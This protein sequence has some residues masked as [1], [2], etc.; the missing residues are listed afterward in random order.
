MSYLLGL[1]KKVDE[2][3]L[4]KEH[5]TEEERKQIKIKKIK[6]QI[7]N[8]VAFTLNISVIM[9]PL[10]A[11]YYY[12]LPTLSFLINIAVVPLMSVV[13]VCG[14]L[15]VLLG[16]IF[17]V[18]GT[19]AIAP[20]C[21]LLELFNVIC[22]LANYLPLSNIVVG[23]PSVVVIVIYYLVIVFVIGFGAHKRR[24]KRKQIEELGR[25]YKK[26]GKRINEVKLEKYKE[27]A[28]V[29]KYRRVVIVALCFITV[30]LYGKSIMNA[31]GFFDGELE[32][33]FL[34]VG[35][36]D[37]IYVKAS[38]GTSM[39]V[40]GGST[41]VKEVG[42][43]RIAPYLKSECHANIDYWFLTHGDEDHISGARE[44][45]QNKNLGI[46]IQKLVLPYMN[47]TDEHLNEIIQLAKKRN[48]KVIRIMKNNYLKLGKTNIKCL[49]PST[50]INSEDMNDYSIVLSVE[51]GKFSE[52]LTGDLTSVQEEQVEVPHKY[53]IL[54]VGHHGSKYSSS[55]QFLNKVK[56]RIGIL[57]SGK[58]NR[59]GHPTPE[60]M[61]R[62][63]KIGCRYIRTDRCGA[64]S[65]SSDGNDIDLCYTINR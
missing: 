5:A 58:G 62:L 33:V 9:A 56:P 36:G 12:S 42:K 25:K 16:S 1:K 64:I 6:N 61:E 27:K 8:T 2:H 26:T 48:I 4:D 35:Q 15:G 10:I 11:Y 32:T 47:E 43:N 52:L 14:V 29:K 40:D 46:K 60:V 34:D 23:K 41:T 30:L 3:L 55:E 59:Y 53:T 21:L 28:L 13:M 49:H 39:M 7:I 54:K 51:Y 57:S 22:N 20:G 50:D 63:S 65:V 19:I 31:F 17:S 18:F 45:I 37:G 38:D 24:Q 44:I